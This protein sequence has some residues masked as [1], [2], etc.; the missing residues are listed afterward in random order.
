MKKIIGLLNYL[1]V[2]PLFKAL[3]LAPSKPFPLLVLAVF[4]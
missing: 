4:L 3:I 1:N 2:R